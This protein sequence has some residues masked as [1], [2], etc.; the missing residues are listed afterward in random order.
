[1]YCHSR[2]LKMP[3]EFATVSSEI[4][5]GLDLISLKQDRLNLEDKKHA[6]LV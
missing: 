2:S 1:M 6:I 4:G 3:Q 5:L